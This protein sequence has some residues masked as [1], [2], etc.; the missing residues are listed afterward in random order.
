[1]AAV[2]VTLF[3]SCYGSKMVRGP[4]NSEH[5]AMQADSIRA[6]QRRIMR[7]IAQLQARLDEE[8]EARLRSQAQTS[9]TL[10]ELDESVRILISR[11]DDT[12]QM[13]TR[14]SAPPRREAPPPV[15]TQVDTAA[16]DSTI[17]PGLTGEST[18]D[19]LYR[20]AYLDLTRGDYALAIQGFQNYLVRF[21][22]GA[23]LAEVQY[24][25][26]ESYYATERYVEAV[27]AFNYVVREFPNS[28]LVPAAY[29][30]SGQCYRFL[31]EK[32]LAIKAFTTL[33]EEHPNSEEAQ[34]ARTALA[35]L[36]G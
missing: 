18:A 24:Y 25:L 15:V 17:P 7:Q 20:A 1:M 35:E 3:S 28:R 13:S 30:K 34:Q 16:V 11:I 33:I 21:P 6:D 26:G 12:S 27:G 32:S 2:A 4:I 14:R 22:N 5:A 19:N 10:Q 8:R 9:V 31:D 29:L 36:E 23:N